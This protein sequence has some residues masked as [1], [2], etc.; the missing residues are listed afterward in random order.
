MKKKRGQML[1]FRNRFLQRTG[2]LMTQQLHDDI[3][4]LIQ[5]GKSIE[6]ERQSNRISIHTIEL[7]G[8]RLRFVYD[9]QRKQLVT[10]LP[11]ISKEILCS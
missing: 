2:H 11:P 4:K 3:V 6:S 9:K 10:V 7:F 8:N 5:S 1:H